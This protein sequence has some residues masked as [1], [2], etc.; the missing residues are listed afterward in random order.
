MFMKRKIDLP[1]DWLGLLRDLFEQPQIDKLREFLI[2]E[3]KRGAIIYPEPQNIFRAFHLT[4]LDSLKVVIL[5]QDPYHGPNQAH[6]L[7]FSVPD[8]VS[9]PPSLR[10]I[11]KEL[12]QDVGC[13]PPKSGDLSKWANSGVLLL[14][15]V[16]TVEANKSGSHQGKGWE[17]FT[18]EVIKRISLSKEHVVF[19]LWGAYAIKKAPLIDNQRHL[20]LQ[21]AHPSPL[22][23]HRGFFSSKPFSKINSYLIENKI[24]PIPWQTLC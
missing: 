21:A 2:A 16:L 13:S 8:G 12:S 6:G 3:K 22:S 24:E 14:N 20:V 17:Q 7:S 10:N 18:D 4:S 11:F 1:P 19:V 23:A 15:S 9:H 5:G